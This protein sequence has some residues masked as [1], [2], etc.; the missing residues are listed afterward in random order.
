LFEV[1]M[2]KGLLVLKHPSNTVLCGF[3]LAP[4][5][6]VIRTRRFHRHQ[7]EYVLIGEV[8]RQGAS[9]KGHG[10]LQRSGDRMKK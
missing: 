1:A 3:E 2:D 10:A 9:I 6:E 8:K 4:G 5:H 7:P